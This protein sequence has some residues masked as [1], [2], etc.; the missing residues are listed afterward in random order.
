MIIGYIRL[1]GHWEKAD[2]NFEITNETFRLS[3]PCYWLVGGCCKLPECKN[4]KYI[5]RQPSIL[6]CKLHSV[7]RGRFRHI[8]ISS[9]LCSSSPSPPLPL[10]PLMM[11][12][13]DPSAFF[14]HPSPI[15]IT[16][17]NKATNTVSCYHQLPPAN[18]L[19]RLFSCPQT[20]L[21]PHLSLKC[22]KKT[23]NVAA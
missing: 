7:Q 15:N 23:P 16:K 1:G 5:E 14:A 20:E 19:A 13:K 12:L 11:T 17:H 22:A 3:Q 18:F 2:T 6:L 9:T 4:V 8:K 10:P 21:T